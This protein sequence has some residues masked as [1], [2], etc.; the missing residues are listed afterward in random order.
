MKDIQLRAPQI[1]LW[2]D[3]E[4]CCY[5]NLW[6]GSQL[7]TLSS[8]PFW[9][10]DTSVQTD[11]ALLETQILSLLLI[12]RF[13]FESGPYLHAIKVQK[14]SLPECVSKPQEPLLVLPLLHTL[15]IISEIWLSPTWG[16]SL[17]IHCCTF[18]WKLK[19]YIYTFCFITSVWTYEL[20]VI[21]A[22]QMYLLKRSLRS[23]Y[24]NVCVF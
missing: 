20:W 6:P 3:H 5:L 14:P 13:A 22:K 16:L 19:K 4:W 21:S 15:R 23:W 1:P 10:P 11:A 18:G 8:L 9:I 17:L 7:K 24:D 12:H 2:S